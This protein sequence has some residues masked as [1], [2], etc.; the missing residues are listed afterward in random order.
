MLY[1]HNITGFIE[2]MGLKLELGSQV[3]VRRNNYHK[4]ATIVLYSILTVQYVQEIAGELNGSEDR[5][6]T[7]PR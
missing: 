6:F 3:E 1:P 7:R 4:V 2:V 5:V